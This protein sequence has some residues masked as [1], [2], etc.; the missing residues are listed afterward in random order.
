MFN[1]SADSMYLGTEV[2]QATFDT[3]GSVAFKNTYVDHRN[4]NDVIG[5]GHS[6][7]QQSFY[8]YY[9][10]FDDEYNLMINAGSDFTP[11]PINF[12]IDD[13]RKAYFNTSGELIIGDEEA[14]VQ[15]KRISQS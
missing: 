9:L 5:I 2:P 12:M 10:S 4:N 7:F 6:V 1:L 14:R 11:Q 13:Q 15:R 8:P 3:Q